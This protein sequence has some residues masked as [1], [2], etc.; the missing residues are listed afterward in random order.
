MLFDGKGIKGYSEDRVVIQSDLGDYELVL[1]AVMGRP[2]L[3]VVGDLNFGIIPCDSKAAKQFKLVNKGK[4]VAAFSI[5][6]DK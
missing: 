1:K 3:E 2:D 6:W 4:A 5:D